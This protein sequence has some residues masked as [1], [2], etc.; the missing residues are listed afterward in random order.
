MVVG[1]VMI[2]KTRLPGPQKFAGSARTLLRSTRLCHQ[3]SATATDCIQATTPSKQDYGLRIF[4]LA[5]HIDLE[6]LMIIIGHRPT[7]LMDGS[8]RRVASSAFLPRVGSARLTSL[9]S[10]CHQ[11]RRRCH[12]PPWCT[13]WC[14]CVHKRCT[15]WCTLW[16]TSG[17]RKWGRGSGKVPLPTHST[18]HHLHHHH[19]DHHHH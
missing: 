15:L 18:R 3:I 19:S 11:T 10:G 12:Q 4:L 2:I 1:K 5:T 17:A 9:L 13:L 7:R 14:T 16:C 6:V 8:E